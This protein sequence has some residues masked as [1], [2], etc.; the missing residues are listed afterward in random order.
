MNHQE[1]DRLLC[2]RLGIAPAIPARHEFRDQRG[3][4]RA[5]TCGARADEGR[6]VTQ[7]CPARCDHYPKLSTTGEGMLVLMETLAKASHWAEARILVVPGLEYTARVA[8]QHRASHTGRA[9][10]VPLA[11]ALAAAAALGIEVPE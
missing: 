7:K 9:T 11:L 6:P 2:E 5:C 1:L 4:P 3:R 10:T 8:L